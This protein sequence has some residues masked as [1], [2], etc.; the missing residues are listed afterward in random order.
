MEEH[1]IDLHHM[2]HDIELR[3][4]FSFLLL[5]SVKLNPG[6]MMR[7]LTD[8]EDDKKKKENVSKKKQRVLLVK[9][10]AEK[11][12][13][14]IHDLAARREAFGIWVELATKWL[15]RNLEEFSRNLLRI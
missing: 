6:E 10:F 13:N 11:M 7:Q 1:I 5:L 2:S 4:P 8:L 14:K 9:Y 12:N 15:M 3:I